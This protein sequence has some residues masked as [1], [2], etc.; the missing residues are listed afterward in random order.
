MACV[1]GM[2]T[3]LQRRKREWEAEYSSLRDWQI[4]GGPYADRKTAQ[5]VEDR[6]AQQHGC[7]AHHGGRDPDIPNGW[8]IYGFNHDGR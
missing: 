1:I 8:W 2:T 5:A 7:Q 4:M 6:L 3:N